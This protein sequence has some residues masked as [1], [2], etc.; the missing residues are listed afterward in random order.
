[1]ATFTV[2]LHD[3]GAYQFLTRHFALRRSQGDQG[4]ILQR[5]GE[6]IAAALYTDS[7]GVNAWV[8][9]AGTPGTPWL[10]RDFL[11]LGFRLPFVDWGL[12]RLTGWVEADNHAAIRLDEHFGYVREATLKGAGQ[13]GQDVYIYALHKAACRYL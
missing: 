13:H 6:T 10:N 11:H 1:M 9:L 3:E 7:N 4:L 8:H 12:K 2:A 5:D